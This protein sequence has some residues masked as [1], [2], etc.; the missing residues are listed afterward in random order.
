MF[1]ALTLPDVD[2]LFAIA[3]SLRDLGVRLAALGLAPPFLARLARVGDRLDDALRAPM[4]IWNA[5]RMSE[6]AATAARLFMLHDPVSPAEAHAALGDYGALR[7]GGLV[8]EG[9]DGVV[10]P[11]H[12]ALAAG[13][14]CFGD[15]PGGQS[16]AVMPLCGATLDL[17]RAA[18]PRDPVDAALDVGCGAGAVGLLLARVARRVVAT[19]VNARAVTFTRVNAAVNGVENIE[20]R[21]GD[22]FEAVAGERYARIAAHPPFLAR[23]SG[24]RPITF[25]HGG[26]RGDELGLRLVAGVAPRLERGGR[27][28]ILADWPLFDGDALDARVRAALGDQPTDVLVLQSPPK[29]LDEYCALYEAVEHAELGDDF[30]RA[31][32]AQ[33]DHLDAL[34]LRGI[35]LAIV[36]VELVE[37]VAS[38]SQATGFT[39]LVGVRHLGDNPIT[40]GAID[41]LVGAHRLAHLGGEAMGGA[42][43]RLPEG[44]TPVVQA[45]PDGAAPAVVLKLPAGRPEWPVVLDA[46]TAAVLR[47][48]AEAPTVLDAAR[49]IASED[50]TS[51]ERQW[52][53]VEAVARDALL[54]G[55]LDVMDDEKR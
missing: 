9:A 16:D 37:L 51:V 55:A 15:R 5:R 34:R 14:Y 31:A 4:R 40:A 54:R 3:P 12:L 45:L 53:R 27:A 41:R 43:L 49:L 50:G 17:V 13:A 38:A 21:R 7:D 28:V 2:R 46:P 23:R 35:A 20:V 48:I 44:A 29:N 18:L 52:T 42:R 24:A 19:D 11:Y 1:G 26:V 22:L 39:S 33:R 6:P 25:S 30:A 8:E 47:R 36:V 10:C 32:V